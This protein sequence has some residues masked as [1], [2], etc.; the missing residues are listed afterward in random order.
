MFTSVGFGLVDWEIELVTIVGR[1]DG[2]VGR[3]TNSGGC[4]VIGFFVGF[5]LRRGGTFSHC[6][7]LSLVT[8][9]GCVVTC[10]C[11]VCAS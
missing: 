4:D 6:V 8:K 5:G 3:F 1:V 11:V 7:G 10:H 2:K 9:F